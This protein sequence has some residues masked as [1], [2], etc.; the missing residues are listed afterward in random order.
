MIGRQTREYPLLEICLLNLMA[1][2]TR[3]HLGRNRLY[4]CLGEFGVDG[5]YNSKNADGNARFVGDARPRGRTCGFIVVLAA[6]RTR[7]EEIEDEQFDY[8]DFPHY[9][10]SRILPALRSGSSALAVSILVLVRNQW[11]GGEKVRFPT[12]T[13]S[14]GSWADVIFESKMPIHAPTRF[15]ELSIFDSSCASTSVATY[16]VY[17]NSSRC[18]HSII[19]SLSCIGQALE[20]GRTAHYDTR[21]VQ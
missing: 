6:S 17:C 7:R 14:G 2:D 5:I 1:S 11:S 19:H 13:R 15:T 18:I 20:Y 9:E 21:D 16:Y 10:K 3:G 8:N 12:K 4:P